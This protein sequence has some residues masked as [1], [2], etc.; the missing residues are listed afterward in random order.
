MIKLDLKTWIKQIR[1]IKNNGRMIDQPKQDQ[2][3][4]KLN[5]KTWI[6]RNIIRKKLGHESL[7]PMV[8]L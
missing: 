5:L 3:M 1:I 2:D 7:K 8:P 4:I 6:N